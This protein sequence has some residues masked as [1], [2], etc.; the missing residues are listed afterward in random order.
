MTREETKAIMAI[1]RAGYPNFYR[2]MT[3][4]EATS[5]INLWATM[6]VEKTQKVITEAVKSQ[7]C[8]LKYLPT[9]ADVKEK[10]KK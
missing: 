4:E 9:T 8:T 6:F 5:A 7:T 2:N 3:K 1:L 10:K